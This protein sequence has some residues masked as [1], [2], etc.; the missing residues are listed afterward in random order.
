MIV[1]NTSNWS[2]A[3][4]VSTTD[5]YR[6]AAFSSDSS[7]LLVANGTANTLISYNTTSWAAT[8]LQASPLSGIAGVRYSQDFTQYGIVSNTTSP[9]FTVYSTTTDTAYSAPSTLPTGA[10]GYNAISFY[11]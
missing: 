4:S 10:A 6:G 9:Y 2:T 8:T 3:T 5:T 11:P 1:Y 7:K